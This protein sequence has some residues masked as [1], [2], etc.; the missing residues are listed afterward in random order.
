MHNG[1]PDPP[2]GVGNE[3]DVLLGI[4]ALSGLDEADV[5]FVDQIEEGKPA[6]TI[7]LGDTHDEPQIGFDQ[8]LEGLSIAPLDPLPKNLFFVRR[9]ALQ[10]GNLLQVLP[11]SLGGMPLSDAILFHLT[12]SCR[13]HRKLKRNSKSGTGGRYR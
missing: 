10:P 1:L 7:F 9:D 6:A 11:Q 4:E 5:A 13:E 2:H 8:P 3:L 12:P